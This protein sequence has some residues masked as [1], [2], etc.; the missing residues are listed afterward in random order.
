MKSN[1]ESTV[2]LTTHPFE[3]NLEELENN[4][5]DVSLAFHRLYICLKVCKDSFF[6]RIPI[7]GLDS[8]FLK[9][10]FGGEF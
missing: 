1:E 3:G 7:I 6:K 4:N 10:P 9:R 8:C 5:S 2:D